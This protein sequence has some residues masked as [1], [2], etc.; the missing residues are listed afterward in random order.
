MGAT[1]LRLRAKRAGQVRLRGASFR[2]FLL[3]EAGM[4]RRGFRRLR[5]SAVRR[6]VS[7]R[8]LVPD[9][10]ATRSLLSQRLVRTGPGFPAAASPGTGNHRFEEG[11]GAR[12][13]RRRIS[14][15]P[16]NRAGAGFTT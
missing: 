4:A 15:R 16:G 13:L 7:S 3:I 10:A 14:L 5:L 2:A 8:T 9:R 6:L 12:A 1:E 11:A